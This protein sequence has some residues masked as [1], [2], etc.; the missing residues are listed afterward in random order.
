MKKYAIF[1]LD[2][3]ILDFTRGET[4]GITAILKKYGAPDVQRG[5]DI[6]VQLNRD[7]WQRIEQ[8]APRQPLLNERFALTFN[9]LGITVDGT[10]LETEYNDMLNHNFYTLPG[11]RDLLAHLKSA[12]V[13]LLVGTNGTK[14]TQ[15]SRLAGSGIDAY[16]DAVYISQD[17][18]FNK[19]DPRFFAPI[20]AQH[21]DLTAANTLMVGD[22]LQSDILGANN[23]RLP[24]IWY[25]PQHTSSSVAYRPTFEA[26]DFVTVARLILA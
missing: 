25:N 19:P 14:H 17:I 2:D 8:G 13:H 3:T 1:D 10:A 5:F 15:L 4:E 23:V 24:S 12:G 7:I 26:T 16:F 21:P 11:A 6:Y 20:F 22:R 18:G 9:A